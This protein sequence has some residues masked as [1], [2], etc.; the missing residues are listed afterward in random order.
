MKTKR[1]DEPTDTA[2]LW[3]NHTKEILTDFKMDYGKNTANTFLS[4]VSNDIK[5]GG[6]GIVMLKLS[7]VG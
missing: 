7:I 4:F 5:S 6:V 2:T 3:H 1:N